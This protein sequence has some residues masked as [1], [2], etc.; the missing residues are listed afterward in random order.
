MSP[1]NTQ[2]E[3]T[4]QQ[5]DAETLAW[6]KNLPRKLV[7]ADVLLRKQNGTVLIVDP[8]YKEDWDL[9][10]GLV[11]AGEPPRLAAAR[12]LGE[13]LGIFIPVGKLLCID[14]TPPRHCWGD[15]LTFVF[16]GG[17]LNENQIAD[18]RLLDGELLDWSFCS[19][20]KASRLLRPSVWRQ[21]NAALTALHTGHPLY[22]HDGQ[23]DSQHGTP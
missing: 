16:D 13:E 2:D 9:P 10:G 4:T 12:E 21:T 19:Q 1:Q 11:E 23:H 6:A 18:I 17:I 22:L 5:D 20:D 14:W 8:S 7:G 3:I 15:T